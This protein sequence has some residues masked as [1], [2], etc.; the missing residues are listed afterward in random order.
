[1]ETE[2]PLNVLVVEDSPYDAK[3]IQEL[4]RDIKNSS[5]FTLSFAET[6]QKGADRKSVV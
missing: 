2:Q 1:M 6:L 5:A 3:I 4:F